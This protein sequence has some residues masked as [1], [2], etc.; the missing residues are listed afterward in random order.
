MQCSP[1]QEMVLAP[2]PAICLQKRQ[3]HRP[4]PQQRPQAPALEQMPA[5]ERMPDA[6]ALSTGLG[7]KVKARL[8]YSQ[9]P[10]AAAP[11]KWTAQTESR[12]GKPEPRR[13]RPHEDC[14][15]ARAKSSC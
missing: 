8:H 15:W 10:V 12:A 1:Q 5:G 4:L 2:A 11:M 3:K 14:H 9:V 6:G 7:P 13:R